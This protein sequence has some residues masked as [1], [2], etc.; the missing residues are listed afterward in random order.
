MSGNYFHNNIF[1]LRFCQKRPY[2]VLY[3]KNDTP[4]PER[5]DFT[6]SYRLIP[7]VCPNGLT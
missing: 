7:Y 6:I 4:K 5:G 2:S 3:E 1:I